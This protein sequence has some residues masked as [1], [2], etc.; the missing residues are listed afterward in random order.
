MSPMTRNTRV[1]PV[2]AAVLMLGLAA[3]GESADEPTTEAAEGSGSPGGES[4]VVAAVPAEESS[5]LESQ[6]D[7]LG[8][9]I[10]DEIGSSVEFQSATDYAAVIEG[11]RAGQIDIAFLG[12]FSYVIA[13]DQG[14]PIEPL[15]AVAESADVDPGYYSIGWVASDSDITDIS[16]FKGQRVCFVDAASTSGF[17]Y[18]SGGLI[19]ADIDPEDDVKPVMSGGHDASMLSIDSGQCDAGFAYEAMEGQLTESGQ[20]EEGAVKEV[21]RS[22]LIS[23]S[24]MVVNTDTV[25][26]DMV[27]QLKAVFSEKANKPYLIEAGICSDESSCP[28]PED[29]EYGLKSVEDADY[30]G[31]RQMCE[32]TQAEA[33]TEE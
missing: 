32:V 20:L 18:P 21:W 14:V 8:E 9:L 24:P 1:L 29:S 4:L 5:N 31:V 12:P 17:L 16:G 27:E 6:F 15:A 11:L 3:C 23:G 33:C 22:P 28:M 10:G 26:A 30:E 2:A 13:K 19:E 25:D 7:I